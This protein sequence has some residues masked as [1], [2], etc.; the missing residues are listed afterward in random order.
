MMN[1]EMND[2]KPK[3]LTAKKAKNANAIKAHTQKAVTK[4]NVEQTPNSRWENYGE[5]GEGE[6]DVGYSKMT[7]MSKEMNDPKPKKLPANKAKNANAKKG[8][9]QKAVTKAKVEKT[10]YSRW[11]NYG[12]NGEGEWDEGYSKMTMMNEEMN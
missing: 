1:E 7:M 9:G 6:W 8:H 12:E 5:N 4:A 11:E 10:P 2:P 3:K